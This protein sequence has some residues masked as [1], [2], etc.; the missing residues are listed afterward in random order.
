MLLP[1]FLFYKGYYSKNILKHL[2]ILHFHKEIVKHYLTFIFWKMPGSEDP[3][4]F[5]SSDSCCEGVSSSAEDRGGSREPYL[6]QPGRGALWEGDS[7]LRLDGVS[8]QQERRV[9]G[10]GRPSQTQRTQEE[11]KGR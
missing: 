9:R 7:E 10:A 3:K 2:R 5:K 6:R 11:E 4:V 1:N 8:V